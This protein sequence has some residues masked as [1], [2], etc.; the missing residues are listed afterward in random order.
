MSDSQVASR[1]S[2]NLMKE[3]VGN[4]SLKTINESLRNGNKWT[5]WGWL[6]RR[7]YLNQNFRQNDQ[8]S[9]I[10]LFI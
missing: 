9:T 1:V 8:I 5:I 4:D 2:K 3:R 6:W 10:I 7:W